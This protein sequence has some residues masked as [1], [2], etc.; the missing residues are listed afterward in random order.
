MLIKSINKMFNYE[1]IKRL[2]IKTCVYHELLVKI[3]NV[4]F[5]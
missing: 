2:F 5:K 4:E 1:K 3:I